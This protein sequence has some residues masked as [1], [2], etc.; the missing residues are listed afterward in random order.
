MALTSEKKYY[1]AEGAE[2]VQAIG[3]SDRFDGGG[4]ALG[5]SVEEHRQNVLLPC[6]LTSLENSGK[7]IDNPG[8]LLQ[9]LALRAGATGA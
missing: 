4:E 7:L 2:N 9:P 1:F 3:E 6:I 5:Q 8:D